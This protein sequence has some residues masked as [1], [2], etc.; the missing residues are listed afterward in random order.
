[1]NKLLIS[2]ILAT[3][4][5]AF[6]AEVKK[7]KV[8]L[9]INDT[10][11]TYNVSDNIALNGGDIV[12][13]IEGNGRVILKGDNYK[14]Q[15]SKRSK[16]CKKLPVPKNV[17]KDYIAMIQ[18]SVV[19]VFANAKE[20]EVDGLSL[21]GGGESCS[22]ANDDVILDSNK[23]FIAI[24]SKSWGPLPVK[25]SIYDKDNK[26]IEE[27]T[28]GEDAETSFIIPTNIVPTKGC[29]IKVSNALG[30]ELMNSKVLLKKAN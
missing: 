12:C 9:Q 27:S 1:M 16:I 20:K 26:L 28:N 8:K 19:T 25:M 2:L 30:E 23:K 4:V 11:K 5:F 21:K 13:F 6:T 17:S 10:I 22:V 24:E 14:K 18:K 3:S 7:D 15:L 29:R